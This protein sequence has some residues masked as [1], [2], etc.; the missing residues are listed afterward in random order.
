MFYKRIHLD[1]HKINPLKLGGFIIERYFNVD[2]LSFLY[3]YTYTK[4]H[5]GV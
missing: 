3:I 4:S 5:K 1:Y 2:G